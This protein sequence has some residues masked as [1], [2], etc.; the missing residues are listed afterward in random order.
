MATVNLQGTRLTFA[1][2][3][4]KDREKEWATTVLAL[5]NEYISYRD[6]GRYISIC[7]VEELIT[8]L[9][10]LLAGVY[11]RERSVALDALGLAV[12]LYA[13]TEKGKPVSRELRREKD[14]VAAFRILMRSKD[15][16]VFLDGVHTLLLHR[17]QIQTLVE[18]LLAEFNAEYAHLLVGEKEYSFVGV[19]P[20]GYKGCNYLY[21]DPAGSVHAGDYVW[22]RMGRRQIE[23]VAYV[24][25]VRTYGAE[26]VPYNPQTVKRV[27]RKATQAEIDAYLAEY[28]K[29]S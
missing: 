14:C 23:Q 25:S 20:R 17:E 15:K 27:L 19:S 11:E 8:S 6:E 5:E 3:P 22:V 10:R 13:Y 12:D 9:S 2:L 21:Y 26:E 24:D 1:L 4:P 29:E 7:A 18:G 16:S 28:H